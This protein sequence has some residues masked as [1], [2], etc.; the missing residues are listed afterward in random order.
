MT[1]IHLRIAITKEPSI[2]TKIAK[3][4]IFVVRAQF[5][6]F[7]KNEKTTPD[8]FDE[9]SK[10][11]LGFEIGQSQNNASVGPLYNP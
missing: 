11:G 7:W 6:S 5:T 3:N 8:F 1:Q 10:T 9:K 4:T 2:F